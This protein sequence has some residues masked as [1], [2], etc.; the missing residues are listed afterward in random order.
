MS[1]RIVIVA[2][3]PN[4]GREAE[5]A[6][7][8]RGHVPFLREHGLATS[9]EPVIGR[10]EDGTVIEVFEWAS[11]EAIERAHGMPEVQEL[12][13][14]F[15]EVGRYEPIAEVPEAHETF[16]EFEALD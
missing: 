7:L 11:K 13:K 5:L 14:R 1:G 10:T 2:Y 6:E 15:G 4:P 9:R 16:S 12:W 8:V 3:L